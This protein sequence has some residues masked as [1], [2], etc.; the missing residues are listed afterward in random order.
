MLVDTHA[1]YNLPAGFPSHRND[2]TAIPLI[3]REV[4]RVRA[5]QLA[6]LGWLYG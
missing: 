4:A 6:T 1:H 3:A 2:S 5:K